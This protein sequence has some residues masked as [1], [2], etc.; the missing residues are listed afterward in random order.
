MSVLFSIVLPIFA[1]IGVGWLA[2][3]RD[4]M[5]EHGA[6]E[7]NRF[8]VYLGMPALLFQIMAKSSWK[9]LD[10][11]GFIAA[12]GLASAAIYVLTVA[13]RR[14]R[15]GALADASLEGLN[16]AYAN[17]GF[18]GFPLCLAAFGPSSMTPVTITAILTV[19]V[20]F[21][22]AVT[23]VE[24]GVS[25]GGS[26]ARIIAKVG[27]SLL[28][29]PM[30]LA[31]ALGALYAGLAPP[32]PAGADRFL[33]LLAQAAS[34]CA[35]V[36]LGLFIAGQR[37]RPQLPALSVQV[38]LKLIGQPLLTWALAAWVFHLPA[39]LT[40]MAVVLAALPTGTGPFMLANMYQREAGGV[41]GSILVSTVLSV[42]TI[43][44]LVSWFHTTA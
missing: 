39:P 35:L 22:V 24:L 17:V 41:A 13:V 20:L 14:V 5:G 7:L 9:Q 1:L 3:Q 19:C 6:F 25:Q 4:W 2:R 43:S 15:G 44:V 18:I 33:T 42:L 11:P 27:W 10:Q 32:L 38:A 23:V 36:S 12:F 28:Q 34:P 26:A 40:G 29:N 8:V 37:G 30:L 21:G 16:A 31:P